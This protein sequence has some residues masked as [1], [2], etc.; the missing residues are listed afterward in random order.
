MT[1]LGVENPIVNLATQTPLGNVA[2]IIGNGLVASEIGKGFT[3]VRQEDGDDFTLGH[4]DPPAKPARQFKPGKDHFL[5]ASDLTSVASIPSREYLGPF[6]VEEDNVSLFFHATVTGAAPL[7][8]NIAGRSVGE[9]W[10]NQYT[11]AGPLAAPPGNLIQRGPLSADSKLAFPLPQGVYYIV[12]E[13]ATP[14]PLVGDVASQVSYSV[15][16]G[17]R[18]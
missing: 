14:A 5:L 4:L 2:T 17:D 8:Y 11:S 18:N 12:V 13:N 6:S 3:V 15:E 16:I 1:I 7:T 9:A 10:R